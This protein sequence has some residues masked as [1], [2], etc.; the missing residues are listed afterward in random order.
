MAWGVDEPKGLAIGL[1]SAWGLGLQRR[2]KF[3]NAVLWT[4]AIP[5][6]RISDVTVSLGDGR[7]G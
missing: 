3:A 4:V 7:R 5:V 1:R 2:L 6:P